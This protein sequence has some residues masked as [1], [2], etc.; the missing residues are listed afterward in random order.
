MRSG[1]T[2]LA[3][4]L[5]LSACGVVTTSSER[6][7]ALEERNAALVD[8]E[9]DG[10]VRISTSR[11][12]GED[13]ISGPSAAR[14]AYWYAAE[15]GGDTLDDALVLMD[16]LVAVVSAQGWVVTD[17]SIG[18]DTPSM[19]GQLEGTRDVLYVFL[20]EEDPGRYS[21]AFSIQDRR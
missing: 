3:I 5:V 7:T 1:L 19:G 2:A 9:L 12:D 18:G 15:P 20:R 21:T 8:F 4:A 10:T 13:P 17:R 14:F 6:L 16:R 11:Y